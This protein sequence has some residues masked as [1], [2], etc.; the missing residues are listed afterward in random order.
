MLLP[1]QR[2]PTGLKVNTTYY[3][4]V[5]AINAVGESGV[6]VIASSATPNSMPDSSLITWYKFD[7][8]SGTTA[9]DSSGYGNNGTVIGGTNATWSA[10]KYDN[11]IAFSGTNTTAAYVALPGNLVDNLTS[12]TIASWVNSS[13][14]ADA[15]SLFTAGPAAAST[16]TKY[17][18]MLLK[19]SRFTITANGNSAEQNI[20]QGSNLTAN[21]W[22]HVAVT[23]SGSTGTL[24][25]D[26]VQVAQNTGMT[27]KPSDL[28]PTT[29]GNFIGKSEWTGDKYLKGLVDDFRIYNRAISTSEVTSVMN[30]Q[31]LTVPAVPTGVS[32]KA[33]SGSQI[34]LGWTAVSNATGYNIKRATVSGG[35]YTT[36]AS[37]VIG[38]SY[39]D[40]GLTAG[41][42]YYYVVSAVNPGHES[43]NS[44][45]ASATLPIAQLKFNETSGTTAADATGSGWNGTLVNGPLWAA[46][47]SGNAVD[48]D[49]TNDYVSLPTGVVSSST[50]STIAAWVNL[51]AV[52]TWMRIFDFGSGTSTY[53]FLTPKNGS[54]KIRFAIRNNGSSEQIIDGT[55]ALP[56]GGWHHVAVTLNG[57]TG[58]LYVDGAQVGQNTA[59]TL[60]PSDMGSTTQNWIGRSQFSTDPYLN[61]RVD[62]FRVYNKALSASEV[63]ALAA[64][65]AG[66][67]NLT[68]SANL[69]QTTLSWSSVANATSYNIKRA[70]VSGGSYTTIATGITGTSYTDTTVTAGTTYY[71][72]VSAV[73]SDF[74]SDNSAEA[75]AT[76]LAAPQNL[77]ASANLL[78]VALSWSA[79]TNAASYNIKRAAAS[80]GGPYTTI[81]TGITGTSYTDTGLTTGTTYYYVVSAVNG[82]NESINSAEASAPVL[83]APQNLT[84][85]A[86]LMTAALSWTYVANATSY[87]IKRATTSGGSYTTITTGITGTSYTDTGLTAGITYY[88]VVSAVN[89]TNESVNSAEASATILA[90]P[91]NLT[92]TDSQLTVALSWSSVANATNYNVKR[93]T[94]QRRPLY[95]IATG[96][97][98]TTYTDTGLTAGATYYYVVS[99]VNSTNES[100]NSAEVSSKVNLLTGLPQI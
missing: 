13:N 57:A 67:Q 59:M 12:M 73:N 2:L 69:L 75:S 9:V 99:A 82:S 34:S 30:G 21:T 16:P 88:Y 32:A 93:A 33:L 65:F 17:M 8:S 36:I 89:S 79:V 40:T 50:T 39:T 10:G 48:L 25:I 28:A 85:S 24:Y 54:S 22:K 71:Y 100:V 41:T 98:G 90:A 23:L 87:N 7:Q 81:A 19:G 63:A 20:S 6:S 29:S 45:E 1:E 58:T 77:T 78:Q 53:M 94:Y 60:K 43:N 96:V 37:G 26:G 56:T 55:S 76:I 46:G 5:T 95:T 61:G 70:A 14:T 42:A 86:N 52:S 38:I 62:D 74:E 84:A 68:A 72:V 97:T 83:A 51:D 11:A 18:M 64:M 44:A 35:P 92:A 4:K 31:T 49:G 66:P 3:Y 47:K 91:Q 15:I 27:L 80:G